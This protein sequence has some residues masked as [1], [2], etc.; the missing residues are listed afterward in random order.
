MLSIAHSR[1]ALSIQVL[2]L[3]VNGVGIGFSIVYNASTPDLYENNAHHKM[4]WVA[5]WVM[6]AQVV[7]GVLFRYSGQSKQDLTQEQ[8]RAPFLPI[9]VEAMAQHQQE[10]AQLNDFQWHRDSGQG[11][12]R[13]SSSLNSLC[14][15]PVDEHRE[16]EYDE[17]LKSETKSE[18]KRSLGRFDSVQRILRN[19]K[20]NRYMSRRVP[21]LLSRR[22]LSILKVAYN[23][24]ERLILILGF[25]T[26][27]TGGVTY[28]GI[29][30][31]DAV[32]NGLAHFIKGGIFFW[33]GLLVL[34]RW[35][36]SFADL[37]WAWNIKPSHTHLDQWQSCMPT[38][39]FV[40]SFL[41]FLYG[42]TNVFLEHLAAWGDRW[43][44]QDLEHVS[45][46]IMFFGGGLCGMLIESKKIRGLLNTSI[47]TI[48]DQRATKLED[49]RDVEAPRSYTFSMNPLPALIVFLTGL[50]MSSHHQDLMV[51]TMVHKQWGMLL[52]GAS[53]ARL[54]TYIIF[55][56]SPPTSVYPSRPPS[57]LICAFCLI[58]GGLIFMASN[59]DIVAAMAHND[60]NAMFVFTVTMGF[61]SF[62]MAWEIIVL[63]IK[64]WASRYEKRL[65]QT[66]RHSRGLSGAT[67]TES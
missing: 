49:A 7:M 50:M 46:S 63:A 11:T 10:Q 34:G 2:F 1:F 57:E 9:S 19:S 47:Q 41:I 16:E 13:A 48:S 60:L 24:V 23:V 35:M 28:S 26:M 31:G 54:A 12:E 3:L 22:P 33:Y 4:G 39:E 52:V 53:F 66:H 58:S 27:A 56:L 6:V 42:S 65:S 30:R 21:S 25:A 18:E 36:G 62:L 17:F 67:V 29:M 14:A 43:T 61:T 40:E 45:I 5:T 44:A 15:S 37:G 20:L 51:S 8:E 32:L 38:S 59:K 64:G 55:Y